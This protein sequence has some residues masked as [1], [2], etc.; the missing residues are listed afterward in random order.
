MYGD[1]PHD[2]WVPGGDEGAP[3]DHTTPDIL[4][5]ETD[6]RIQF[7]VMMGHASTVALGGRYWG[8]ESE[9]IRD[10]PAGG[11]KHYAAHRRE[12]K[13]NRETAAAGRRAAAADSPELSDAASAHGDEDP[14]K[15][16]DGGDTGH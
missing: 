9:R 11:A 4:I 2:D 8:G 6:P 1:Y 12:A 5:G 14:Y 10:R 16:Q 7:A 15:P 13:I 3:I